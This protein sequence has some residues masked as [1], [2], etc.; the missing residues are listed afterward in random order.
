LHAPSWSCPAW[1]IKKHAMPAYEV[2]SSSAM[3]IAASSRNAA[4]NMSNGGRAIDVS[5]HVV[6]MAVVVALF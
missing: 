3:I 4:R 2:T 5:H 1:I 6:E